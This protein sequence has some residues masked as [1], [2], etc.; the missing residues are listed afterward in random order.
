[1]FFAIIS[2]CK[3]FEQ[4][5][6]HHLGM[7]CAKFELKLARWF[8]RRRFLNFVSVLIFLLFRNYIPLKKSVALHLNKVVENVKSLQTGGETQDDR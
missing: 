8:W 2:P 5:C 3:T 6:L 7:L 1:M 4:S